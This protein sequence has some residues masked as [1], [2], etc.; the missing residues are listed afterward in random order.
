V[1][2]RLVVDNLKPVVTRADR[3][4][5]QI[6]RVFLEYAPPRG[7]LVDPTGP[8]HATGTPRVERGIPYVRQD[9][10]RG[11]VFRDLDDMQAR[12]VHWCRDRAGTRIHGPTRR[13]PRVV[14]EAEE[15][16]TL[17]PLRPE[18][19][20]PPTWASAPSTPITTSSSSGP[21]TPSRPAPSAPRS[22]SAATRASSGSISTAS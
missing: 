3:Y 1:V 21:S 9:F 18:P 12:A 22:T 13:A 2:R 11:A 19:F 6:D 8:R 4:A 15:Q 16:P 5:P 17:R 7:F 14:F 20:D 10:F